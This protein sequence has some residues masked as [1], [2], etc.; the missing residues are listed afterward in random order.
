MRVGLKCESSVNKVILRSTYSTNMHDMV[1]SVKWYSAYVLVLNIDV[2][3]VN[4]PSSSSSPS[5]SSPSFL[6][7]PS[8]ST[9]SCFFVLVLALVLATFSACS[10]ACS[11]A[12]SSA[13]ALSVPVNHHRR[14]YYYH[15]DKMKI[16][17]VYYKGVLNINK[18]NQKKAYY[19][20]CVISDW[21]Q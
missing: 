7:S 12:S 14:H 16:K 11:S 1:I 13:S 3:I 5:C 19:T 2:I 9:P 15:H 10:L 21:Y 17:S 6:P 20:G 8:P 4:S 18:N